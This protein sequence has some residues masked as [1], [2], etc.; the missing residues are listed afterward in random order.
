MKYK[1]NVLKTKTRLGYLIVYKTMVGLHNYLAVI[2]PFLS[3]LCRREIFPLLI[4]LYFNIGVAHFETNH[5][6]K[7]LRCCNEMYF[8]ANI[9]VVHLLHKNQCSVYI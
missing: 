2:L 5:S 9:S 6:K 1:N 3:L 7:L 8:V 4:F